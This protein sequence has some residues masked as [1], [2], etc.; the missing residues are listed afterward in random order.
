M[1]LVDDHS[2]H[3]GHGIIHALD[4][5]VAV[6]TIGACRN[7]AHAVRLVNSVR[8]LGAELE[9]VVGGD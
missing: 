6:R 2:G 8:Q 9:A 3:L 4:A 7:F 5:A 1:S